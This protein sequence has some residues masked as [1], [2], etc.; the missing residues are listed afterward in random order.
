[1]RQQTA[2]VLAL[3]VAAV[4][5]VGAASY[6]QATVDRDAD[7]QV[8]A[9][10]TALVGLAVG[11]GITDNSVKA[12]TDGELLLN[13]DDG[14]GVNGNATFHYGAD[15]TD[16]ARDRSN[17]ALNVTN[18]D[19]ESRTFTLSYT[20]AS[21]GDGTNQNVKFD[22]YS[23]D[24]GATNPWS[25]VGTVT[26]EG[27]TLSPSLAAG[28]TLYVFV[29]VDTTAGDLGSSDDLSGTFSVEAS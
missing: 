9:D 10:N 18:N 4:T 25:Q 27:D 23:Y 7:I 13:L 8:A 28:E 3:L 21:G 29:T 1:M 5:V 24:S 26:E 15:G 11:G 22:V 12:S 17:T 16:T 20:Q 6:T 19:D 2:I 14:Q